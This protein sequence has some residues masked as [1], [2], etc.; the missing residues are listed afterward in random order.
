LLSINL[1]NHWRN[2]V[3]VALV[4]AVSAISSLTSCSGGVKQGGSLGWTVDIVAGA[5][6]IA[7]PKRPF[8][9][10]IEIFVK[11]PTGNPVIDA[12][13]EFRLV[14]ESLIGK[15][16][17]TPDVLAKAWNTESAAQT[18]SDSAV[19]TA[20]IAA[21][22]AAGKDAKKAE[23][24]IEERV[25]RIDQFEQ[26]TDR[27][28]RAKVW[29][30]A[31]MAFN[32]NVA[33]LA[34]AGSDISASYSYAVL[35]TPDLKEGSRLYLS[36]TN[37]KKEKAG[38]EFDIWITIADSE[39]KV[40]SSFEGFRR[41]KIEAAPSMSWAGF[42]PEFPNG[43]IDCVFSGGR[44]LVPRGPFKLRVPEKVNFKLSFVDDSVRAIEDFVEVT[45]DSERAHIVVKDKQGKPEDGAKVVT[46]IE[47]PAGSNAQYTAAW[48]DASGNYLEEVSEAT[49]T[50]DS[51]RL[52]TGLTPKI[53]NA[54][55]GPAFGKIINFSPLKTGTGFLTV[56]TD[57][58]QL[59]APLS[60]IIPANEQTKW[61]F[62][63]NGQSTA[64]G[65]IKAG[66]CVDVDIFAS[67]DYGNINPNIKGEHT[68]TLT[69]EN[70]ES[71][72]VL[73]KD[74]HWGDV[75]PLGQRLEN[76][77]ITLNEGLARSVQKA[78]FYDATLNGTGTVVKPALKVVGPNNK[79][80]R[81]FVGII[82]LDIV[83]N[84]PS[85][86]MI[87]KGG[88]YDKDSENVCTRKTS[89]RL[90]D[91]CLVFVSG[92]TEK[93]HLALVD[94]AGNWI[95]DV[96]ATWSEEGT[97]TGLP[98]MTINAA[99]NASDDATFILN[100][101]G[102]GT[103]VAKG[104]DFSAAEILELGLT[105]QQISYQYE[106]VSEAPAKLATE[107]LGKTFISAGDPFEIRAF[108]LDSKGQVVRR[109]R[110]E[111]TSGRE[112]YF[113]AAPFNVNPES[114]SAS[115]SS[116]NDC[117]RK[118]AYTKSG[119]AP[120]DVISPP[121]SI[122]E[123]ILTL[124]NQK[125][126]L[127]R[128]SGKFGIQDACEQTL[129]VSTT[130]KVDGKT[131]SLS[132]N[133]DNKYEVRAGELS[134]V[135]L[136]SSSNAEMGDSNDGSDLT[137]TPSC[138]DNVLTRGCHVAIPT[139]K[140]RDIYVAGY[141]AFGNFVGN[142]NSS[143]SWTNSVSANGLSENYLPSEA[144]SPDPAT[145]GNAGAKTIQVKL[146]APATKNQSGAGTVTATTIGSNKTVTS[147][148]FD[149]V[150]EVATDFILEFVQPDA[151]NPVVYWSSKNG[152]PTSPELLAGRPF[153]VRLRPVDNF[154]SAIS[155]FLGD[156]VIR[157]VH[158]KLT[159]W[160]KPDNQ[161][162]IPF[163]NAAGKVVEEYPCT[164]KKAVNSTM[165]SGGELIPKYITGAVLPPIYGG[166]ECILKDPNTSQSEHDRKIDARF[167][168]VDTTRSHDFLIMDRTK[169]NGE[170]I[171]TIEGVRVAS[172]QPVMD[173]GN[174]LVLANNCGGSNN[175]N[176]TAWF[177]L[178]NGIT[179][180]S[181]DKSVP[182]DSSTASYQMTADESLTFYPA[183]TDLL[184]NYRS[185]SLN[186]NIMVKGNPSSGN[187]I[188]PTNIVSGTS[189]ANCSIAHRKIL[190]EANT[191]ND[192]PSD[193]ALPKYITIR[194]EDGAL[195]NEFPLT[196]RP[197]KP[198]KVRV[199][200]A[201]ARAPDDNSTPIELAPG[202]VVPAGS[203]YSPI[204]TVRDSDN[205]L[206][207]TF[208]KAVTADFWLTDYF[209]PTNNS[210][211][212]KQLIHPGGLYR[213]T[214][215]GMYVP[216]TRL[217]DSH[218]QSTNTAAANSFAMSA[219]AM[220]TVE[221]KYYGSERST[222]VA[223]G[224][225]LDLHD[226]YVCLMDAGS[227]P[228]LYFSVKESGVT[229]SYDGNTATDQP[230][231]IVKNTAAAI[232]FRD[233]NDDRLC[234]QPYSV[235]GFPAYFNIS[236]VETFKIM[237]TIACRS[238][239][240]SSTANEIRTYWIDKVGN[241]I[242]TSP[243]SVG[244]WSSVAAPLGTN[245]L[246]MGTN[247]CFTGGTNCDASKTK[248]TLIDLKQT[249][250]LTGTWEPPA[251][252]I[253]SGLSISSKN[254]TIPVKAGPA[255]DFTLALNRNTM[256]TTDEAFGIIVKLKD[257]FGNDTEPD[258]LPKD[259]SGYH[260]LAGFTYLND[261]ALPAPNA[262]N[263]SAKKPTA[264]TLDFL[265]STTTNTAN[266]FQF[267]KV[268]GNATLKVALKPRADFATNVEKTM[269][270]S[271]LPG[272]PVN[273]LIYYSDVTGAKKDL[274]LLTASDNL[275]TTQSGFQQVEVR[276]LDDYG[277]P[278]SSPA[279]TFSYSNA[280]NLLPIQQHPSLNYAALIP[281]A[282]SGSAKLKATLTSNNQTT[283]DYP[284]KIA[285]SAASKLKLFRVQSDG[286]PIN[287]TGE[288]PTLATSTNPPLLPNQSAYFKLKAVDDQ[289]NVAEAFNQAV[290]GLRWGFAGYPIRSEG[291]RAKFP[292]CAD[293]NCPTPVQVA[294]ACNIIDGVCKD[295][296]N[297][298]N[299]MIF[300]VKYFGATGGTTGKIEVRSDLTVAGN[301]SEFVGTFGLIVKP[302][303]FH[304]Y[305]VIPSVSSVQARADK[306]AKF[307]VSVEPRDAYGNR[308]E[309]LDA[310][311]QAHS[312]SLKIVREDGTS[313]ASGVLN[314]TVTGQTFGSTL[315]LS[316][317]NLAY[318]EAGKFR[319]VAFGPGN[320]GLS[321]VAA[322]PLIEFLGGVFTVK[323]YRLILPSGTTDVVAGS[324]TTLRF[325]AVD[326]YFNPVRG[327]DADL[328]ADTYVWTG[329]GSS[330]NIANVGVNRP[331]ASFPAKFD[332]A[333]TGVFV[334]GVAL[335]RATFYEA[336]NDY[337]NTLSIT[338]Q[339]QG[340]K[341]VVIFPATGNALRVLPAPLNRYNVI[342]TANAESGVT[343]LAAN[344]TLEARND[345]SGRFRIV[346]QPIDVYGNL[347][348]GD[349]GVALKPVAVGNTLTTA[350]PMRHN[351]ATFTPQAL[352]LETGL[353]PGL[354]FVFNDL[355]YR[356]AQ[357]LN[358]TLDGVPAGVT[359]GSTNDLIYTPTLQTIASYRLKLNNN[360]E[361]TWGAITAG[362][363]FTLKLEPLDVGGNLLTSGNTLDG[364]LQG[365]VFTITGPQS[366]GSFNPEFTSTFTFTNGIGVQNSI[367]FKK[368]QVFDAGM[369]QVTDPVGRKG[370]NAATFTISPAA[371]TS[372]VP[373][374][375]AP[376]IAG[377][378]TT[379]N[380]WAYDEF[381]N[382]SSNGCSSNPVVKG[383]AQGLASPGGH[384]GTVN[385]A[386]TDPANGDALSSNSTVGYFTKTITFYKS[387]MNSLTFQGCPNFSATLNVSVLE[388]TKAKT[389]MLANSTAEPAATL[390]S[391]QECMPVNG[392]SAEIACPTIYAF[393]WDAYGNRWKEGSGTCNWTA[394]QKITDNSA[395]AA[396]GAISGLVSND[397]SATITSNNFINRDLNCTLP[398]ADSL[399]GNP[400]VQTV[401]LFG[402]I[403][404][405]G[406]RDANNA[407]T[408]TPTVV[409]PAG[410]SL[411]SLFAAS[412]NIQITKL[413]LLQWRGGQLQPVNRV[414]TEQYTVNSTGLGSNYTS[415][416][417]PIP[418][419]LTLNHNVSGDIP[420]TL[421]FN[422]I[423]PTLPAAQDTSFSI[424]TRG[425]TKTIGG[426]RV[427]TGSSAIMVV[428]K[429]K[430]GAVETQSV[431]AGDKIDLPSVDVYDAAG[432]RAACTTASI[433]AAESTLPPVCANA[434]C[435]STVATL[436]GVPDATDV[437]NFGLNAANA[438]PFAAAS[439]GTFTNLSFKLY[440][441][442]QAVT[443][444]VKACG[445]EQAFIF[446][447]ST[448]GTAHVRLATGNS[449]PSAAITAPEISCPLG[450][451]LAV[452]CPT[453]NAFFWD[454]Y[455]N[456]NPD[457]SCSSWSFDVASGSGSKTHGNGF[458]L[459]SAGTSQSIS[460]PDSTGSYLSG[461]LTCNSDN[462]SK[463]IAMVFG[464]L[465]SLTTAHTFGGNG[466]ATTATAGVNNLVV[467]SVQAKFKKPALSDANNITSA[468][469]ESEVNKNDFGA[470]GAQTFVIGTSGGSSGDTL[471]NATLPMVSDTNATCTFNSS[472]LCPLA[473]NLSLRRAENNRIINV[474]Y[475][476][477]T[478]SLPAL[479]V[480][481]KGASQITP[482][483][484]RTVVTDRITTTNALLAG[485]TVGA[486]I[487][488]I[489]EYGNRTDFLTNTTNTACTSANDD[490]TVVGATLDATNSDLTT[491]AR[492]FTK[493]ALGQWII[494]DSSGL[495]VRKSGNHTLR[496]KMCG[497]TSDLSIKVD[498]NVA[499]SIRLHT[500]AMAPAA[501]LANYNCP[502]N[503]TGSGV[504]CDFINAYFYDA[505][506][507]LRPGDTCDAWQFTKR[508]SPGYNAN[509]AAG[510]FTVPSPFTVE[511][512][513]TQ[514]NTSSMRI[515]HS[516]FLDGT[517]KCNKTV[518]GNSFSQ[519]IGM[520]GGIVYLGVTHTAVNTPLTAANDNFSITSIKYFGP[521]SAGNAV[522][523]PQT[524]AN[525][526]VLVSTNATRANDT[527]ANSVLASPSVTC[528]FSTGD[529]ANCT[530]AILAS[531]TKQETARTLTVQARGL[532][533][534]T[535]T[536]DVNP[537][538]ADRIVARV[539]TGSN[540]EANLKNKTT[541]LTAGDAFR[542][543]INAFDRFDNPTNGNCT[544]T[545][546]GMTIASSVNLDAPLDNTASTLIDAAHIFAADA[547]TVGQY[548]VNADMLIRKATSTTLTFGA[549]GKTT[550]YD[551]TIAPA[552]HT[553]TR[554]STA[555]TAPAANTTSDVVLERCS[556]AASGA[557]VY[558]NLLN[559]YMYD[560]YGNVRA[561]DT[562]TSWTYTKTTGTT[563]LSTADT[564]NGNV[565][566]SNAANTSSTRLSSTDWIDGTLKCTAGGGAKDHQIQ[567]FGGIQR[568]EA[569]HTSTAAVVAGNNNVV[570]SSVS[571]YGPK[572]TAATFSIDLIADA[573]LNNEPMSL[574][575]TATK[576]STGAP[577]NVVNPAFSCTFTNGAC[578]AATP[579]S[580]FNLS[581][582]NAAES[583]VSF[584]L[585][586]RGKS[587]TPG[588]FN[589]APGSA[590]S[591]TTAFTLLDASNNVK[592]GTTI[593]A[594]D[595]IGLN[596]ALKDQFGNTTDKK[597]DGTVCAA[598][599]SQGVSTIT[600]PTVAV[601]IGGLTSNPE[602]GDGTANNEY[603]PPSSNSWV[604]AGSYQIRGMRLTG[605]GANALKISTCGVEYNLAVTIGAGVA[606]KF[607]LNKETTVANAKTSTA[608][609]QCSLLSGGGADCNTI[610]AWFFD[611]YGNNRANDT[612]DS[613]ALAN[614][615]SAAPASLTVPW[616]SLA[617]AS[618]SVKVVH[619]SALDATLTCVKAGATEDG[620]AGVVLYG[621]VKSIEG[622][623]PASGAITAA[624]N[625]FSLSNLT[626][627][628]YKNGAQ[629]TSIYSSTLPI[630][631]TTTA[632]TAPDGTAFTST[633]STTCA[634]S[635]GVCNTT[636]NFSFGKADTNAR[637]LSVNINGVSLVTGTNNAVL[638]A[639]TVAEGRASATKT[640]FTLL[641]A[642]NNVK[643]G[644][645]V[646]ASDTI[647]LNIALKDDFGNA[648]DK[649]PDG[650]I[651]AANTSQGSSTITQPAA[652]AGAING[653]TANPLAGNGSSY[654]A[655]T[656]N[657]WASAGN[658]QIRGMRL[659]GPGSNALKITTCAVD[660]V[661]NVNVTA[662]LVS[663]Y[664]L[665]SN[666]AAA[667]APTT[668]TG[669]C[670][671]VYG[672]GISCPTFYAW[673]YDAYDNLRL[674]ETC[675]SWTLTNQSTPGTGNTTIPNI[676]STASDSFKVTHTSAMNGRLN[677]VKTSNSVAG[678]ATDKDG[679]AGITLYGGIKFVEVTV[680]QA[681]GAVTAGANNIIITGIQLK[682]YRGSANIF[683]NSTNY[684]SL[685]LP[686]EFS[687]TASAGL[688][689][690]AF[691]TT[692]NVN[693]T[694]DSTGKCATPYN[695][696]FVRADSTART[697][698]IK[699]N[700]VTASISGGS[701]SSVLSN[702]VVTEGS[703][704]QFTTT[705]ASTLAAD[706]TTS[707]TISLMDAYKNPACTT[708][709]TMS[710]SNVNNLLS[711][712][713]ASYAVSPNGTNPQINGTTLASN[714]AV[715]INN[716]SKGTYNIGTTSLP[717][718]NST[719]IGLNLSACGYNFI[720]TV[721]TTV[722]SVNNIKLS[723]E[724]NLTAAQVN[725][726]GSVSSICKHT[727]ESGNGV[728]CEGVY[729]YFRDSLGNLIPSSDN[730]A[731]NT[732][733]WIYTTTTPTAGSGLSAAPLPAGSSLTATSVAL[734]SNSRA[735]SLTHSS[736]LDGKLKCQQIDAGS[737]TSIIS[738]EVL[739]R[740]GIS[741]VALELATA[742]ATA[743]TEASNTT[744][745]TITAGNEN[746]GIWKISLYTRGSGSDSLVSGGI[747][748]YYTFNS[749]PIEFVTTAL[750][751][752][753]SA[754][755][756]TP[757]TPTC[758][759][760]NGL[761]DN[762]GLTFAT[763][764]ASNKLSLTRSGASGS[765]D[766]AVKIRGVTSNNISMIV[767]SANASS[768]VATTPTTGQ[769]AG[770][771]L[772]TAITVTGY[773]TYLNPSLRSCTSFS[774]STPA[775]SATGDTSSVTIGTFSQTTNT[776]V[777]FSEFRVYAAGSHNIVLTAAGCNL[778]ANIPLTIISDTNL[779]KIM[780][781]T[782][783]ATTTAGMPTYSADAQEVACTQL[784]TDDLGV[785]CPTL[786]A[787]HYD[788]WGN[789]LTTTP[790]G[791]NCNW[792]SGETNS[793]SKSRSSNTTNK[794]VNDLIT[795]SNTTP[796]VTSN[797][798]RLYGG[799]NSVVVTSTPGATTL[800][801]GFANF[802]I[803]KVALKSIKN[804]TAVAMPGLDGQSLSVNFSMSGGPN[805]I[806][807]GPELAT[808]S[809]IHAGN[810]TCTF[811]ASGECS[812]NAIFNFK[813]VDA[814]ARTLT[815][816]VRGVTA[817]T[818]ITSVSAGNAAK[819]NVTGL[820][821]SAS[822][823]TGYD[824]DSLYASASATLPTVTIAA[825]D[826]FDNPTTTSA[827]GSACTT[828]T[829][830]SVSGNDQGPYAD[831]I[832]IGTT[833]ANQTTATLKIYK[834]ATHNLTFTKCGVSATQP[835]TISA[836]SVRRTLLTTE[837]VQPIDYNC[838]ASGDNI[839]TTRNCSLVRS[840]AANSAGTAAGTGCGALYAWHY[841]KAGNLIT[842]GSKSCGT[843]TTAVF[844]NSAATGITAAS[845]T[846]T[847][848]AS[849]TGF[850]VTAPD[851]TRYLH[852]NVTCKP[853]TTANY[854]GGT[855]IAYTAP[856]TLAAP[857]V[858][859]SP[860][861][862]DANSLPFSV[863][864]FKNTT[865][866]DM[867][868]ATAYAPNQSA[869]N[870][871]EY[872]VLIQEP[873]MAA[874]INSNSFAQFMV[875]GMA[876]KR[877]ALFKVRFNSGNA[878]VIINE[879][880]ALRVPARLTDS[881]TTP[882]N[883]APQ[884]TAS[885]A[886]TTIGNAEFAEDPANALTGTERRI[887]HRDAAFNWG[888]TCNNNMTGATILCE[889]A[890]ALVTKDVA[891]TTYALPLL[892]PATF[893]STFGDTQRAMKMNA[894][895]STS[896]FF[897]V[898][899]Q[900]L[901]NN[902]R[903]YNKIEV[904][905]NELT[906]CKYDVRI[907][908]SKGTKLRGV[909]WLK[910]GDGNSYYFMTE[911]TN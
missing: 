557:G 34:K 19:R 589:V 204:V 745:R 716:T 119:L 625:N 183:I 536:F 411:S 484:W 311:R 895:S 157:F 828:S 803:S 519:S 884:H 43:E 478:G 45:P 569:A 460:T 445:L 840:C 798:V 722:G 140:S 84:K 272:A 430:V 321:T 396:S 234:R 857:A 507:N 637:S 733:Y 826:A 701:N 692:P 593:P 56:T 136:R 25:G 99:S 834:A 348:A 188:T 273:N 219:S 307:N 871:E 856:V 386:I 651:C 674:G 158:P 865:G 543:T 126:K 711:S 679:N 524:L 904:A 566:L 630:N 317:N 356:V 672:G 394:T 660:Y 485:Q 230:L 581:F 420:T 47:M 783:N 816:S 181:S 689:G 351:D 686:I 823:T 418:N 725:T 909:F 636:F 814:T 639:I 836:G 643:V 90:G 362:T 156:K 891:A 441:S 94:G 509:I 274:T 598:N 382:P 337:R 762:S 628:G 526:T 476:G 384:G 179:V 295:P 192:L 332:S 640:T 806:G 155:T 765:N 359:V 860:W 74:A 177:K 308:V 646:P 207:H 881:T 378:A 522:E 550:T 754:N 548:T 194:A 488:V 288:D 282:L 352:N 120:D 655:P 81:E 229:S 768:L 586:V 95:R 372:L 451:G 796:A 108:I 743:I 113:R 472:G 334:D 199:R 861:I 571:L 635:N 5:K 79:S 784:N 68:L 742:N 493:T 525:E 193:P 559:A 763:I 748:G 53:N 150:S 290:V 825:L 897:D 442:T 392:T 227:Q 851:T 433:E 503:A 761:C 815:T 653:I 704:T 319:V 30:I 296:A 837:D 109:K 907:D 59:L 502:L 292:G 169:V 713:N 818:T 61:A 402:G 320:D 253:P 867:S 770:A 652:G 539:W 656:T 101:S 41:L 673:F 746:T 205:N 788:A 590:S 841:D 423:F 562:C 251:T 902:D 287:G 497:L 241:L 304:H 610:N 727:T 887:F 93:L 631:F 702:I 878:N 144:L 756:V 409:T 775:A 124:A 244:R 216:L 608:E 671:T 357:K 512:T 599:T 712:A 152:T 621:G 145:I 405:L 387:G 314:G 447:V 477:V 707:G 486:D 706:A 482:Y 489:D 346:V 33:V 127:L 709:M 77:L 501:T 185:E 822:A 736:F 315:S 810:V 297:T 567:F 893:A 55:T 738:N 225:E 258:T 561:G 406:G 648:T 623:I 568:V 450:T 65:E 794:S 546:A 121:G 804:T 165:L 147:T 201:V 202:S 268:S 782:T 739:I 208:S 18:S 737:V 385:A 666:N 374:N 27:L 554:V 911:P 28:G 668:A 890:K 458:T 591:T 719:G 693:C 570:I 724:P 644:N 217:D 435:N 544:A 780:L 291:G 846:A 293:E 776:T 122:T 439:P 717:R 888:N 277:N 573:P 872:P 638:N 705:L 481:P 642:A 682:H 866:A 520:Y 726:N 32:K 618:N 436:P 98:N 880:D 786:Y 444:K 365:Q 773:D 858:E 196:I 261:A 728:L 592:V 72:P 73:G 336:R 678:G 376:Q 669:S 650:T 696:S 24:D 173:T 302:G 506:G 797:S 819:L 584:T 687:T 750:K 414:R 403:S 189:G 772:K 14:D 200:L 521:N 15:E 375:V 585:W 490:I 340:N 844:E 203:C 265:T 675:D 175:V 377:V 582:T 4:M 607:Y 135:R 300:E 161:P 545:Q 424:T 744:N 505:H 579:T 78:C 606:T 333:T 551:L 531:F 407:A 11:D 222:R 379:L 812:P 2:L 298:S 670:D 614:L 661:L 44:C 715:T 16:N 228:K 680:T 459:T 400:I 807:T 494:A 134:F 182:Y 171:T 595:T 131:Y 191:A 339:S 601:P 529:L 540:T 611:A 279:A 249:G 151:Q 275:F 197:G 609:D 474:T 17:I 808:T 52:E 289:D 731:S 496:F 467:D 755:S 698:S 164:F 602:D 6:Q 285:A 82:E 264:A 245:I 187:S 266:I 839:A 527:D 103:L 597:T 515:T 86:L 774:T 299:D 813:K 349:F 388:N 330:G 421:S 820:T 619:S 575:T 659:T 632:L 824:V 588:N 697:L 624:A 886:G 22:K 322:A 20:A 168:M 3:V 658:Y 67:D 139:G 269:T 167:S 700:G 354:G 473:A 453:V 896:E 530:T 148:Y 580:A 805:T 429:F 428:G 343:S 76:K 440:K 112:K 720:H 335:V 246:S 574:Q 170:Y 906:A 749:E 408:T 677:C 617:Q 868:G 128:A 699:V 859:C 160:G 849:G 691:T 845:T 51:E 326:N 899:T 793:H 419:T 431:I 475:R 310:T 107:L 885:N 195:S 401:E 511:N 684:S 495:S 676:T 412:G 463:A 513:D 210:P 664:R 461:R 510:G 146:S 342:A 344:S 301:T 465:T 491:A 587:Y 21:A 487:N 781:S 873:S 514:A 141:D 71:G 338:N 809:T 96:K 178:Q 278:T 413:V 397:T 239:Q 390:A 882:T 69:M 577:N 910:G 142:V 125:L 532:S 211:L 367:K 757:S 560:M 87:M 600:P 212:K 778:T 831:S 263:G 129:L 116:F 504:T 381:G 541:P 667:T 38:A 303:A 355:Y 130:F 740:G 766:V 398:A 209:H 286:T 853:S 663:Q 31:P 138:A 690:T 12:S 380:L 633:P 629:I 620:T 255:A 558:C 862:Y 373:A 154:K 456:S 328:R 771:D 723:T 894:H 877:T 634:F 446:S 206:V 327:I 758:S 114:S 498:A 9:N 284:I 325:E 35:S 470:L 391:A 75:T 426:I 649:K 252:G 149:F 594:S 685:N 10:P 438:R 789:K 176:A 576:T 827:S 604:S 410:Q 92:T 800:T 371:V 622:T 714:T 80:N 613:W 455:G 63:I 247:I 226:R 91:P 110:I 694:L 838:V 221:V 533:Y 627:K 153:A 66:T 898:N 817:N 508:A 281:L 848:A 83:K 267:L 787:F 443:L 7:L 250:N 517:L 759:F 341:A 842:G 464:G 854:L 324:E 454:Q 184:G 874:T 769:T 752:A 767:D 708:A 563:T 703:P 879:S 843:T 260:P 564:A 29:V 537:A 70:T 259:G 480:N 466:A 821:F 88:K 347:R 186:A 393:M 852:G 115:F 547:G 237:T 104:S 870:T 516:L 363:A 102:T 718:V 883:T 306:T 730:N 626:L 358:W 908:K 471:T 721:K 432:N 39:G 876:G 280:A 118:N 553:Y 583:N 535:A 224:G 729:A 565:V 26:R 404:D 40:A 37:E 8:A 901:I 777:P 236:D 734:T 641:D 499:N 360:S 869:G 283:L 220:D 174:E 105:G 50:I 270:F 760:S 864:T 313:G 231:T 795:C 875:E 305:G 240:V 605:P 361:S 329:T 732:C 603:T 36:T 741:K 863:C 345:V 198:N 49:W 555:S 137:M 366:V 172:A 89:E 735:V 48:I 538:N 434:A 695:F 180:S 681:S 235:S 309:N 100:S 233:I 835:L 801:A 312:I 892:W 159:T 256:P 232:D 683:E 799:P 829:G 117:H 764:P 448:K 645:T 596:I 578:N 802:Q 214:S 369:L 213:R 276:S 500:N 64:V 811:S 162:L 395:I 534:T 647:G 483:L 449:A 523:L 556:L 747:A 830:V 143:F 42:A 370:S 416:S 132:T 242:D 85:R 54:S 452:N 657:A 415:V 46:K 468:I 190:F 215:D 218:V 133:A 427:T 62:R 425:I 492:K 905:D 528:N 612:C 847:F 248:L 389:M 23:A 383:D 254:V 791:Q 457:G 106:I 13:V 437:G 97:N 243:V 792:S 350:L 710:S 323:D 889:Q 123:G 271:I 832:T 903:C 662:G 616:T 57:N 790:T 422:L 331:A 479:T 779:G 166:S 900:Y 262:N 58:K 257:E 785:T 417:N 542:A 399:S 572:Y 615:S 111:E 833:T 316:Y 855:Q 751:G 163:D 223:T 518:A 665:N 60:V 850:G 549:C 753:G 1:L 552:V 318:D 353:T 294:T 469:T 238:L 688:D 654:T 364:S 462:S 368:A